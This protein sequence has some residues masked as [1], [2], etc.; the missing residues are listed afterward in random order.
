MEGLKMRSS[1]RGALAIVRLDGTGD[2]GIWANN[3]LLVVDDGRVSRM[4]VFPIDDEVGALRRLDE[5][6]S[7]NP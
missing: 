6:G 3:V 7:A 2:E 1:H 4:E 5:I